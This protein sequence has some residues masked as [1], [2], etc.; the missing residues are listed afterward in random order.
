MRKGEFSSAYVVDGM[1]RLKGVLSID[2]ALRARGERAPISGYIDRNPVTTR[3]DVLISDIMP[4]A[5]E[6]RYPI[7]VID[8]AGTLKGIVSKAAVIASLI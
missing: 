2:N 7:A 1:M 4:L 8:D 3:E 5:V 6:S